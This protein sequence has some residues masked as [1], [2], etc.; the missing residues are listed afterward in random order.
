MSL[1]ATIWAWKQRDITPTEKLILLSYADRANE[2]HEAYP[3]WSRLILDT[4]LNR[5]TIHTSLVSLQKKGKLIKTGEKVKC[6]NVYKLLGVK[7]RDDQDDIKTSTKNG[8]TLKK[9]TS[10]KNGTTTSTKN[11]TTTSTKNGTKNLSRNLQRNLQGETLSFSSFSD[12]KSFVS[13]VEQ[14]VIAT[15]KQPVDVLVEEVLYTA[16]KWKEKKDPVESVKMAVIVIKQGKWKTPHGFKGFSSKA[17]KEKEE[18]D[19]RKKE[20]QIQQDAVIGRMIKKAV[21]SNNREMFSKMVRE[22]SASANQG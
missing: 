6:V 13:Y 2:L 10:T 12:F 8:T 22:M 15:G 21:N 20:N 16:E 14:E 17:V 19:A 4:G 5:K 9:K 7:G 18:Q 1:D 3:A 11:G